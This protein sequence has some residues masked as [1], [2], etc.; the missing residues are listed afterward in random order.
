MKTSDRFSL[1]PYQVKAVDAVR[2]EWTEGRSRTLLCMA[3][4][5]G[6]TVCFAAIADSEVKSGGR[7][8]VLAHRGELLEQAKDKIKAVTGLDCGLEKGEASSWDDYYPIVVGS[9]QT[10]MREKRLNAFDP[11]EF[12][13]IIV[14]EA[15]HALSDSYKTVLEYFDANVLGV[16][17][18]PDRGDKK[19]LGQYFDSIAFSYSIADAIRDK[20][21]CKIKAITI[22]LK[23][24][25]TGVSTT[26][27]DYNAA[28]V[29]GALA[30]YL[31]QIAKEMKVYCKGK[32]TVVF[33]PLI[34]TS[35]RFRD[36]LETEGFNAAE[37]NGQSEDR[38]EI[39]RDFSDGKYD[40]LCNSMLL[41]EGW[42][43]PSVDCI[44]CLRPT[45]VRSLYVQIIGRGTRL[46]HGKDHLLVLDFLWQTTKHDLVRPAALI[47]DDEEVQKAMV[48]RMEENTGEE[49]GLEE[50]EKEA[51]SDV[52]AEREAALAKELAAMRK[53]K[54]Q[55][56]DPL[57]WEMSIGAQ[58][59]ASY[60]P[61]F[62]WEL[63]PMTNAQKTRLEALGI[64][65]DGIGSQGKA[66]ALLDRL[67]E[68]RQMG[69]ATPKQIRLLEG[70]GFR[71]VGKWL[72]S[73]ASGMIGR[74]SACGWGIPA[75]VSP[76]S[77]VPP[78]LAPKEDKP[79]D[80]S[81][82]VSVDEIFNYL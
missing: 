64:F 52:V 40:V 79:T 28:E 30:P 14:D 19:N 72:L 24:D 34:A 4:G 9:I 67:D 45:K 73:E 7:V 6:K 20:Y 12:T 55:L 37:V 13:A 22:P 58:D 56:V 77:Y 46:Y 29:G 17:A 70:R 11:R 82:A 36:L 1:R 39:L 16:T 10:M 54:R 35:Q 74:I 50:V 33:L 18:T 31:A 51:E 76:S 44:V 8:L 23:V 78:S 75:G 69:L 2:K 5:T 57:Q 32:K 62:G 60:Q 63:E 47:C 66:K 65:P 49:V 41:T 15:H 25:L 3:T 43:C 48:K 59:L 81:G 42:D 80:T 53:R 61:S 68:R 38:E 27:G 71:H 26:A 21:L